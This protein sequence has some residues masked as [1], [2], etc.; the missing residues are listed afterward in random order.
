M[1]REEI[2]KIYEEAV[3]IAKLERKGKTMPYTSANGHMF[4][5]LNKDNELGIRLSREDTAKFDSKYGAKP[6][7]S[8]GTKMREY[9]LIPEELLSQ[10]EELTD[11]LKKG[12]KFVNSKPHK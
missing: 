4:S 3:V 7:F 8:Y 1:T 10:K 2:I 5:Q 12:F 9:V 11:Y 6:F